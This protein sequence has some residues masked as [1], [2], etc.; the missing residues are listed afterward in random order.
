MFAGSRRP[1]YSVQM[2]FLAEQPCKEEVL[3]DRTFDI[4]RGGMVKKTVVEAVE[5]QR[6]DQHG[7]Y[8]RDNHGKTKQRGI[9]SRENSR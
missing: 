6:L 5:D 1:R 8:R 3:L 7:R 4:T 2:L 9:T